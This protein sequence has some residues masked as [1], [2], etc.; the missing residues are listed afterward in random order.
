M[1]RAGGQEK[2]NEVSYS[3]P[4][5]ILISLQ[6]SKLLCE[7]AILWK[8]LNHPNIVP[9]KGVT[10]E[11][12]QLVSEWMAG[13]ELRDYIKKR[14]SANLIN[15]VGPFLFY[16]VQPLIFSVARHRQWSCISSLARGYTWGSQRGA[17]H[18]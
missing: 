12:P 10:L 18:S 6:I 9:F 8:Y 5:G 3:P 7:E 1:P 17:C 13:G 14:P 2:I 4:A 16:P 15:L 11:P